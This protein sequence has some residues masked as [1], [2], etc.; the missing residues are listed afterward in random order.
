M[1]GKRGRSRKIY[2]LH[3]GSIMAKGGKQV[4]EEE[5]RASGANGAGCV[6]EGTSDFSE[7]QLGDVVEGLRKSGQWGDEIELPEAEGGG[8]GGVESAAPIPDW[9]GKFGVTERQR[10]GFRLSQG[11]RHGRRRELRITTKRLA[12]CKG[13]RKLRLVLVRVSERVPSPWEGSEAAETV[14]LNWQL[15]KGGKSSHRV[16]TKSHEGMS[17]PPRF[18]ILSMDT[19]EVMECDED[20]Q[21]SV[22]L[23]A[24]LVTI[25]Y[26]WG[27]EREGLE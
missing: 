24:E 2:V 7:V 11:A 10:V 8:G 21:V 26:D 6:A 17:L 19:D 16:M 3:R 5:P 4:A 14:E 15:V 20:Q 27:V 18:V 9:V 23:S 25:F 22:G 1:A 13:T 12:R